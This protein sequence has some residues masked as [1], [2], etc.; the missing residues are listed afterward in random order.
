MTSIQ[1]N[2][3]STA[4]AMG[5]FVGA[6][7]TSPASAQEGHDTLFFEDFQGYTDFTH[8]NLGVDPK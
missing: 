7:F 3:F 2:L 4:L 1:K 5:A 6:V 8:S